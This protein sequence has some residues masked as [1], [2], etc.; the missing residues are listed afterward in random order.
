[1]ERPDSGNTLRMQV[2]GV[3]IETLHNPTRYTHAQIEKACTLAA[4]LTR[5]KLAPAEPPRPQPGRRAGR[6]RGA[7]PAGRSGRLDDRRD[8]L[9]ER[10]QRDVRRRERVRARR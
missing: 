10:A 7:A 2:P 9:V 8:E 4:M 5:G 3:H 6:E 1:M